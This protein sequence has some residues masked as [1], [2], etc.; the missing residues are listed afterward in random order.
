MRGADLKVGP[1]TSAPIGLPLFW[2]LRGDDGVGLLEL[3]LNG[4]ALRRSGFREVA[5]QRQPFCAAMAA[6]MY[7]GVP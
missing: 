6:A 4:R 2:R 3:G 7:R 1:Y 5:P